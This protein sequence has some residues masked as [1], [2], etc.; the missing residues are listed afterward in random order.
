MDGP[1]VSALRVAIERALA[2][3]R[4]FGVGFEV[5]AVAVFHRWYFTRAHLVV[6]VVAAGWGVMFTVVCLRRGLSRA[7]A[8]C[9]LAV[10][11]LLAATA[12]LSLPPIMRGGGPNWVMVR[13]GAASIAAGWS[14]PAVVWVLGTAL[15]AGTAAV[16]CLA[17]GMPPARVA[18]SVIV[19]VLSGVGFT[20]ACAALRRRAVAAD[21][22]LAR[23]GARRREQAV[24][25]ARHRD[26]R[27][28]ERVLHDTVLNTLTGLSWGASGYSE[29]LIRDRCRHT[30]D[31]CA[32]LLAGHDDGEVPLA[33]RLDDVVARARR[34][35][36]DVVHSLGADC[37]VV[38]AVAAAALAAA[39]GETLSNVRRHACTSRAQVAVRVVDGDVSVTVSDRG[40]GFDVRAA[41]PADRLGIRHSIMERMAAV[42]GSADVRSALGQGTT[43]TLRWSPHTSLPPAHPGP[44]ADADR[45]TAAR[46]NN[47]ARDAARTAGVAAL[48]WHLGFGVLLI[49][50]LDHYRAPVVVLGAAAAQLALLAG[51]VAAAWRDRA[52]VRTRAVVT[53]AVAVAATQV[54]AVLSARHGDLA[55][56]NWAAG[57]GGG[58]AA[59]LVVSRPAR[60]WAWM[61][62]G[63]LGATAAAV[64]WRFGAGV[65]VVSRAGALLYT[66]AALLIALS[67]FWRARSATVEVAL[68]AARAE[69]DLAAAR[70]VAA[71][72]HR[73]RRARLRHLTHGTFPLLAD[74]GAGRVD[75]FD[76]AVQRRSASLAGALRRTL[77]RPPG[78]PTLI[79]TFEPTLLAAEDR[80]VGVEVQVTGDVPDL[81]QVV[82]DDVRQAVATALDAVGDGR[83]LLTLTGESIFLTITAAGPAIPTRLTSRWL[84]ILED[85]D[86]RRSCL[87]IRWESA[88]SSWRGEYGD[89][90]PRGADGG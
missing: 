14:L 12:P 75:P 85:I 46:T 45:D 59:F 89:T 57:A 79:T 48:G 81:P 9:E 1:A 10:A 11:L 56:L 15:I 44:A 52:R 77:T 25:H 78:P 67:M 37:P 7:A 63:A 16:S 39:L 42:G 32:D 60:E 69:T 26:Q 54:T 71:A 2:I 8:G 50:R 68:R 65:A 6:P 80:G 22:A 31:L 43:V 84:D 34:D 35:G 5:L 24:A 66:Q 20:M 58:T 83:V 73:D 64:S 19:V 86:D 21:E 13:L 76:P 55:P 33:D 61:A 27:E 62:L 53:L 72:V 49:A 29:E 3:L 18:A 90:A 88:M 40:V 82:A 17:A 51:C 30:V 74:I 47:Y 70:A 23:A 28:A 36:L 38:P 4:V 41:P 87:E